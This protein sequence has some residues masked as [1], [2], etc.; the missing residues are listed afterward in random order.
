MVHS[1]T[2]C[3]RVRFVPHNS[4]GVLDHQVTLPDGTTTANSLRVLPH[5]DGAEVVFTIRQLDASA[6]AKPTTGLAEPTPA[7]GYSGAFDG[8]TAQLTPEALAGDFA[9]AR[10]PVPF[11]DDDPAVEDSY[12]QMATPLPRCTPSAVF[13]WM[14]VRPLW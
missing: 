5:P 3:V 1:P 12:V 10:G 6:T 13:R 8:G 9:Y 14:V 7:V 2:G 4:L 11:S